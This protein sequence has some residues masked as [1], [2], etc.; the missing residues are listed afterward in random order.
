MHG[1]VSVPETVMVASDIIP[2]PP[3]YAET[4]MVASDIVARLRRAKTKQPGSV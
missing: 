4:V 3:R 2:Y 1:W